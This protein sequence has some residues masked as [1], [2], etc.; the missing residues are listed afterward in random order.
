MKIS[1]SKITT[2]YTEVADNDDFELQATAVTAT[3]LSAPFHHYTV[4]EQFRHLPE[5]RNLTWTDDFFEYED[6]GDVV[7]V[8]DL[9]YKSMEKFYSSVGWVFIGLSLLYTPIF[10]IASLTLAPCYLRRNV[11]WNV[12]AKHVAITRDGIRFV[13][14]KR[15]CG[16]GLA[17]TD[18]GKSIKTVPFDKINDCEIVEPA[19]NECLCIP[20]VLFRVRVD[21]ASSSKGQHELVLA[22]LQ[23]PH[24]FKKLVWAMKRAQK[25]TTGD[26]QQPNALEMMRSLPGLVAEGGNEAAGSNGEDI[27]TLLKE[28]RDELRQNNETMKGLQNSTGVVPATLAPTDDGKF[29]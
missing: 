24:E 18:V 13:E 20:R 12:R 23:N 10:V 3:D 19:G 29:V 1:T 21:T 16:W 28:I 27:A 22:G 17:C 15:A 26:L 4:S 25:R 7:A 9:D 2:S 14:D 8:F 11:K 5:A 6:A